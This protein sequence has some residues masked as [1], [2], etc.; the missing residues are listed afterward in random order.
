MLRVTSPTRMAGRLSCQWRS[1]LILV[2]CHGRMLGATTRRLLSL[3]LCQR[4]PW[5]PLPCARPSK[6]REQLALTLWRPG[7]PL[8]APAR[9][10]VT[11]IWLPRARARALWE[12]ASGAPLRGPQV[13]WRT[14]A[15]K[16]LRGRGR[17]PPDLRVDSRRCVSRCL[18]VERNAPAE[19]TLMPFHQYTAM[20]PAFA[21]ISGLP[22]LGVPAAGKCGGSGP[23]FPTWSR[24]DQYHWHK[25]AYGCW[26]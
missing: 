1:S 5:A 22:R 9:V 21:R 6:P 23:G 8:E 11:G 26:V 10:S 15:C 13:G 24:F 17:R 25:T 18:R 7:R 19:S 16:T 20:V 14:V 3:S 12:V 4:R 2:G